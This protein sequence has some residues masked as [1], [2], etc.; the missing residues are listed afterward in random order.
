[1]FPEWSLILRLNRLTM[2]C[3]RGPAFGNHV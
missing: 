3:E 2:I 1:L